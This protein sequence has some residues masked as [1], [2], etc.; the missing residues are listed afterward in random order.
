MI[1]AVLWI[2]AA[3]TIAVD[4]SPDQ[5]L[6]FVYV[7]DPLIV[8]VR[9][10]V[11]ARA[12]VRLSATGPEGVPPYERALPGVLL[13]P[14]GVRWCAF[15]DFPESRG[16]Y[17]ATV[18]VRVG[19]EAHV[20][21]HAFAR[22]DRPSRAAVLPLYAR[23]LPDERGVVALSSVGVRVLRIDVLDPDAGD[24]AARLAGMGF[25]LAARIGPGFGEDGEARV[26]A[27]AGA[28][29]GAIHRWEI[30]ADGDAAALFRAAEAIRHAE[31]G[32]PVAL[33]V[34]SPKTLD[35]LLR[36]DGGSLA[37]EAVLRSDAP[38]PEDLAACRAA[39]EQAGHE[40]W[41]VHVI[42]RGLPA[43]EDA[44]PGALVR[45]II[46]NFTLGV[47][48]TG[49]DPALVYADG[50]LLPAMAYLGG[51][52]G[53]LADMR[54][55]GWLDLRGVSAP[56]FR[57]G[58]TWFLP[59]WADAPTELELA[60]GDAAALRLT[61]ALG[62]PIRLPAFE[63]GRI[64]LTA[65]PSPLYLS[66]IRGDLP[67]QA[68]RGRAALL[69]RRLARSEAMTQY[70]PAL[71]IGV[72][73]AIAANPE[74]DQNRERLFALLRSLPEL[75]RGW[76]EGAIPRDIA[77]PAIAQV[78]RLARSLC[79]VEEYRGEPFLEPMQET[80]ARCEEYQSLYLTG[81]VGGAQ[82][83]VRGDWLLNEVRRLMDEASHLAASDRR[84]EASGVAAL[85]EWRARGLEH[86]AKAGPM[87][88]GDPL[89][90]KLQAD[91][92][93]MLLEETR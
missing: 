15:K 4:V 3:A 24:T 50:A 63:A 26:E 17:T 27:V 62:N 12:T 7:D 87:G 35:A 46:G 73:N 37:H 6:P 90:T 75:E 72:A 29:C 91:L 89:P 61:D 25:R 93:K 57:S 49:F 76:H 32:A 44:P 64:P 74:S 33:V 9:A 11:E 31:C 20:S 40:D 28:A 53:R 42:G 14:E 10:D 65:G 30:D 77:V 92:A 80:L 34:D 86:A 56:L 13:R 48:E 21:E 18:E 69:G 79:T 36:A 82:T 88:G 45:R 68:A 22:I 81:S 47:A 1:A 2:A 5:P 67:A 19:E 23:R 84:I 43:G 38:T 71:L 16:H 52:A 70:L 66:G 58:A 41:R 83:H 78:A 54:F 85:A 60:V 51:L 55:S 59:L 39:I 8:E